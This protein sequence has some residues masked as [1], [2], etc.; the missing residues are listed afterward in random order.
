ME[1]S[2]N[3]KRKSDC[4]PGKRKICEVAAGELHVKREVS[5]ISQDLEVLQR[6]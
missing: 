4:C 6:R 1:K 2:E 5:K 3:V